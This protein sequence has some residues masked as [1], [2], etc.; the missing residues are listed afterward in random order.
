MASLFEVLLCSGFPTQLIITLGLA[1]VGISAYGAGGRLSLAYVVWLSLIDTVLVVGLAVLFLLARGERPA[2][3]FLG[4]RAVPRELGLGVSLVPIAFL[5]VLAVALV[6]DRL[7]PGLRS[8]DGNPLEALLR[9]AVDIATFGGVAVLAGG[10]REELQRA[11]VLHRFEQHLGGAT[12][13]LLLF[14][15]AFG[16][17]HAI[18]GWDAAIITGLLGAFWGVVYLWRRSVMAPA[19]CHALFNLVEV[20]YHGLSA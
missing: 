7:A 3:V 9:R 16:V 18:Q 6:I 20:V 13:G 15:M 8:P 4:R 19:V 10:I 14:S 12:L 5:L 1:A 17:G 2:D 11:F